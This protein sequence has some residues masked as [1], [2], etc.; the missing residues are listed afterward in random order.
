MDFSKKYGEYAL[1]TG[2]SAGIG[3]EFSYLL[4]ERGMNLI[5]VARRK[6]RLSEI[7]RELNNNYKIE[8]KTLI[9]DLRDENSPFRIFS[10]TEKFDIGILVNN[11]G[12]GYYGH[13][14]NQNIDKLKDMIKVNVLS[15]S[16]LTRL[17]GEYFVKRRRGGMILVSSLAAFQPTPGMAQ[18]GATKSFELMLGEALQVE[19]KR[20]NVDI[21]ILC[22]GATVTEFQIVAEGRAHNGMDAREVALRALKDLGKKTISIPG[23]HNKILGK[24]Y[25]FL[26][27][28]FVRWGCGKALSHYLKE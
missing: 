13:F 6:E 5:L 24:V 8:C 14:V 7:S 2:A 21:T 26:P 20:K 23:I 3:K 11:A 1:I 19:L 28:S 4:A 22:P 27:R 9:E 16:L 10:L 18:Y 12:F 15:F 25:R 17:F